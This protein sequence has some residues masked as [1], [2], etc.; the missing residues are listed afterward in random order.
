MEMINFRR[1]IRKHLRV[2][3]I[4]VAVV[5]MIGLVSCEKSEG[6]GGTGSIS[7]SLILHEFNDD[8]SLLINEGP[9][10]DEEVFIIYGEMVLG[11]SLRL[12]P[13]ELYCIMM[14]IP[15]LLW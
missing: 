14:E 5:S 10:V 7:G 3:I 12:A 2:T 8:Y 9:A 13:V 15:G 1:K 4:A 11:M 6:T